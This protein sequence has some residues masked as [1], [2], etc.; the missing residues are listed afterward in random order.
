MD[1][2]ENQ[3]IAFLTAKNEDF[4]LE[5]ILYQSDSIDLKAAP[6]YT[7]VRPWYVKF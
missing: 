1:F 2:I 4:L 6:E 3:M 5:Y 7:F